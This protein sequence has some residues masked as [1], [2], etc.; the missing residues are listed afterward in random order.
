MEIEADLGIDSIKR[1]EIF[2]ALADRLPDAPA[3][4]AEHLGTLRTLAQVAE[5]LAGSPV[6][7]VNGTHPA[8]TP[9]PVRPVGSISRYVVEPVPLGDRAT[10]SL[11][12]GGEVW[13]TDD[14]AGLAERVARRL[15]AMGFQPRVV[16]GRPGV[17]GPAALAG[18]VILP[19]QGQ[20]DD[21]LRDALRLLRLAGPGLRVSGAAGG[22]TFVTVARLD[23]AFGL[24]GGNPAFD[25]TTGGL[26]GFAKTAGHEWPEVRCRAIDVD[27]ALA[28]LDT[29]AGLIVDEMLRDGPSEVGIST[30]GRSGLALREA[31]L[32]GNGAE[33]PIAPGDV[34][35]VTG[36][37]RGV[38]AEVAV[39]LAEEL[40]PTLVLLGRSLAPEAEPAWLQSLVD[41]SA[42]KR[43][44]LSNKVAG[45][46]PRDIE[47]EYRRIIANR[48]AMRTIA[49]ISEAG[50]K[51]VYRQ[52]DVRDTGAVAATLSD[53]ARLFGPIRGLVHGAGVLADAR[54]EDK[55]VAQFDLV[56]GTKVDGLRSLLA[57]IPAKDSLRVLVLVSSSTARFGRLGQID[58]AAANEVLNKMAIVES[59]G[60]PGCRVVSVNWGPWD[61]G[62]VTPT[63]RKVF[64]SEG[65]GLIPTDAGAAYLVR[66]IA[67]GAD[68]AVEVVILGGEGL[69][70]PPPAPSS[71]PMSVAFGRELTLES[72]PVLR[73]HAIDGRAVLP[74]AITM[75]WLAHAAIHGNPGLAFAGVEGLRVHR[76][77]FVEAGRPYPIRVLAGK[78]TRRDGLF[79]V[80]TE[81]RGGPIDAEVVHARTD[82]ILANTLPSAVAPTVGPGLRAY[83][84]SVQD[85]YDVVLFH[86]PA[87]RAI[88]RVEGC[89][90]RGIAVAVSPAPSPSEWMA[91]P[92][93][94]AW[95]ADPMV[96]DAA[97]QA[98][99]V[100]SVE[101]HGAGS[102]PCYLARYRQYRRAFPKEGL[103]IVA[104]LV[105]DT[106]TLAVADIEIL[107]ASGVVVATLGGYECVVD[108]SLN[109]AFRRNQAVR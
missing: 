62:M 56:Y 100:W 85:I 36:G 67:E 46:S 5:F 78:A 14:G 1:V 40:T 70:M 81:L 32:T 109:A 51:V 72:M 61:G 101:R 27:P 108:A 20:G 11:A 45:T 103:R 17:L 31:R 60:R 69:P 42:I 65:V 9:E 4:R 13:I 23:G 75:E 64:A 29:V 79:V 22:A 41:E 7:S 57:A 38:T 54:I 24:S 107:D 92:P 63:L 86:G 95:L 12:E 28:D 10:A 39:A 89:S 94:G 21:A 84:R 68:G 16:D 47:A 96:I 91:T 50:A 18:L 71:T 19:S 83:G 106:P 35:V 25:P 88:T 104:T 52:V 55:T 33:R 97:F 48:E 37:A 58:Y 66:E 59:K 90:E 6:P 8:K 77:V 34:V 98:M 15:D 74:M 26:A 53:I 30:S 80:P 3:I 44:V 102:L 76:G 87:L 73:S 99:I 43:A 93:R 82:V 49:R 2:G 105:K